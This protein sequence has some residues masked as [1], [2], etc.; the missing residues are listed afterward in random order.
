VYQRHKHFINVYVWPESETRDR[1][2]RLESSQG[3]NI[4]FWEHGGMYFCAVSDVNT[5]ELQQFTQLLQR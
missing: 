4:A 2:A 3:Y 5:S 1:P